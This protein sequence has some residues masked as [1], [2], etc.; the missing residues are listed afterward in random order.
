M[1]PAGKTPTAT[2]AKVITKIGDKNAPSETINKE[3]TNHNKVDSNRTNNKRGY[4][5]RGD[6]TKDNLNQAQTGTTHNIKAQDTP[7]HLRTGKINK[8]TGSSF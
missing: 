7:N 3:I 5:I 2:N 4:K 8:K 1:T 6:Q